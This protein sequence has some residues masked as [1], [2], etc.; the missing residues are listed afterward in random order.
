VT[1]NAGGQAIV[2]AVAA[3]GWGEFKGNPCKG[4]IPCTCRAKTRA[5]TSCRVGPS[6]NPNASAGPGYFLGQDRSEA[7]QSVQEFFCGTDEL[8]SEEAN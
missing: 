1:V 8:S 6:G 3:G 5:G 4:P 7:V 2:G